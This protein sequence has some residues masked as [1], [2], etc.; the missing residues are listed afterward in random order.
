MLTEHTVFKYHI[1]LSLFSW[2]FYITL[3]DVKKEMLLWSYFLSVSVHK[4]TYKVATLLQSCQ[5]LVTSYKDQVNG[6]HTV[7]K[8]VSE[9]PQVCNIRYLGWSYMESDMFLSPPSTLFQTHTNPWKSVNKIV[10]EC[11]YL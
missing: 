4:K 7:L 11:Y 5:N 2:Y 9:L 6:R 3:K 8:D 1:K 10:T